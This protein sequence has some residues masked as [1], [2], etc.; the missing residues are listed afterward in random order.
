V[1]TQVFSE[2]ELERLRG[3]PEV[4]REQLVRFFTLTPTDE[5]FVR[6]HRGPA[7]RLGVAVQ[8]CTLPWLGFVPDDVSSAPAQAAQRLAEHLGI[9]AAP[10]PPTGLGTRP[11]PIT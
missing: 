9:P 6:S 3:F 4:D 10:S 8:L 2:A 7:N 11:A 1:A 5:A